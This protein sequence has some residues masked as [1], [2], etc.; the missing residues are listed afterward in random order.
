MRQYEAIK[1]PTDEFVFSHNT[2]LEIIKVIV[3]NVNKGFY[4]T[5]NFKK[6]EIKNGI[7]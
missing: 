1:A 2:Q 5:L 3:Q 4:T 6:D 7:E